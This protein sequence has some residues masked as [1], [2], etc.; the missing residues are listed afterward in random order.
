[1]AIF[2]EVFNKGN[3]LEYG[4]QKETALKMVYKGNCP[5]NGLQSKRP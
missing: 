3:I 2:R 4:L 5:E 1:V